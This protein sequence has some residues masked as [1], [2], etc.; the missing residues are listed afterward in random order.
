MRTLHEQLSSEYEELKL[1]QETLRKANRDLRSEIRS[2]KEKND[3]LEIKV[4]NSELEKDSLRTDTMNLNNL[5]AEHSKL[6][7]WIFYFFFSY[8]AVF[9][10]VFCLFRMIL[11]IFSRPANV[12]KSNTETCKKN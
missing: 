12:S 2:L 1:E 6:K 4:S 3:C 5:R 9:L 10:F 11:G 7:V 8:L